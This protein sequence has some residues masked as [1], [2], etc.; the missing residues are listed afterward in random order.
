MS[1]SLSE[2][3][4]LNLSLIETPTHELTQA[5]IHFHFIRPLWLLAL[6]P[7][8]L[9]IFLLWN[10]KESQGNWHKVIPHHLLPHLLAEKDYQPNKLPLFIISGAWLLAIVA[11]SGPTWRQLPQALEQSNDAQIIVLDLSQSMNALDLPP[12]RI[13]RAKHKL[14]DILS[15][16]NGGSTSLIVYAGDAHVVIPLTD[17]IKTIDAIIP[18]LDPAIMPI[19]GS[20]PRAAIAKAIAMLERGKHQKATIIM[21]TDG[22]DETDAKI[23]P[24]MI[25]KN[26]ITLSILGIG[27]EQGAPIPLAGGYYLK[28]NLGAIVIPKLNRDSLKKLARDLGGRYSEVSADDS[29][30]NHLLHPTAQLDTTKTSTRQFDIWQEDGF[31]LIVFILPLA[32][33]AFRRGWLSCLLL[34]VLISHPKLSQAGVWEDLWKTKDQQGFIAM[35]DNRSVQ[36]SELFHSQSWKASALYK[37]GEFNDSE[38][39][40]KALLDNQDSAEKVGLSLSDIHYNIGNSLAQTG[41]YRKA[42]DAYEQALKLAL[43]NTDILFNKTLVEKALQLKSPSPENNRKSDSNTDKNNEPMQS[44]PSNNQKTASNKKEKSKPNNSPNNQHKKLDA[45]PPILQAPSSSQQTSQLQRANPLSPQEQKSLNQ[46]LKQINEDPGGLLRRKFALQSQ[47]SGLENE[48]VG[49]P[50]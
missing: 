41:Q 49:D 21:L 5:I 48:S 24:D 40:Y 9:L 6:L 42:I 20:N 22:I 15:H 34:T 7:Y 32:S 17:D 4:S 50:W 27:T 29:D 47:D 23:I 30:I 43:S 18:T 2:I 33:L 39:L 12:N 11:L 3:V 25:N 44:P 31:W 26:K 45:P 28:D 38:K 36:A 35:E 16:R 1:R 13:T 19:P 46:W 37:A 10:S 8:A 14:S